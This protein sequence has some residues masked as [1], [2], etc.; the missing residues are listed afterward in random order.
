MKMFVVKKS[1]EK[2]GMSSETVE[3]IFTTSNDLEEIKRAVENADDR[4]YISWASVDVIDRDN[5]KIPIQDIIDDQDTLLRRGGPISDNHTNAIVGK[6][7]AYK[8]MQHPKAGETGV[9]H[10][11]EI[12]SDNELDDKVWK[13]TQEGERTGSSVGGFNPPHLDRFEMDQE[14]G[15]GF[16]VKEG[17][18]QYETASVFKPA[19]PL[20]LNEAV[21][22]VAKSAADVGRDGVFVPGMTKKE[23]VNYIQKESVDAI[24]KP[25]EVDRCVQ[26]LMTDPNFEPQTGRTKEESAH[27]ICQAQL[28]KSKIGALAKEKTASVIKEKENETNE[29]GDIM[30][31][32][33]KKMISEGFA[34]VKKEMDEMR[35]GQE[36]LR[37]RLVEAKAGEEEEEQKKQ[38]EE[39]EAD[40][41]KAE[42]KEEELGEATPVVKEEAASDIEGLSD[43]PQPDSPDPEKPNEKQVVES[44]PEAVQKLSRE[45]AKLRKDLV[46]V[47]KMAST[48]RPG[49]GHLGNSVLSQLAK[50]QQEMSNLAVDIAF[51][52]VKKSWHEIHPISRDF[53]AAARKAV[54]GLL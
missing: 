53:E 34:T 16:T 10:L 22:L 4:L 21:S 25:A 26:S 40:A 38:D 29:K 39:E 41:A 48:P 17:F 45:L 52:R 6:T 13:E 20:A 1:S 18:R 46:S 43:A 33:L 50:K 31:E 36:E 30:T 8:V 12:F 7:R 9:L 42:H 47:K 23:F 3:K 19:N 15:K 35:E 24:N 14:T 27:A 44:E 54:P 11:N 28:S 2:G 49:V 32:E 51:G 5:E 37:A